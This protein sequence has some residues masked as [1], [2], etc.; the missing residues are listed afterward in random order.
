MD[1][2]KAQ[3]RK[4]EAMSKL[5]QKFQAQ[6]PKPISPTDLNKRKKSSQ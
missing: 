5:L 6:N 3:G 2:V 1:L 4:K